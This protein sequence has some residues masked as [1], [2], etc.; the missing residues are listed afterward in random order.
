[1]E[2]LE[3]VDWK[4]IFDQYGSKMLLFA[5][6]FVATQADAEDVVQEAFRRFWKSE[7]RDSENIVSMLFGSVR[8]A[9]LDFRRQRERRK[10]REALASA[11]EQVLEGASMFDRSLEKEEL[12]GEVQNALKKLPEAQREIVTLKVWGELTYQQIGDT[13]G[14]SPNTAS[15][16][17]RYALDALRKTMRKDIHA[18]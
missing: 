16:R 5:K 15:S 4:A 18:Q 17:Y 2:N 13:L 7:K 6:Q 10:N 8:W 14:I 9:A 1:M 11:D 3:T 12:S